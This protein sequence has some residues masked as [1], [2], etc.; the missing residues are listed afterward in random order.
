MRSPL[1]KT[2]R[3]AVLSLGAGTALLLT[4]C[5]TTW[6]G[7]DYFARSAPVTEADSQIAG[8][9]LEQ[10]KLKMRR[11]HQDLVSL[12]ATVETLRRHKSLTDIRVMESYLDGYLDEYVDPMI[13]EKDESWHP[14]LQVLDA[15]LLFA[16]AA[17]LIE[18]RDRSAVDRVIAGIEKR[19]Q[20]MNNLP[21]EYPVGTRTTLGQGLRDLHSNRR[22]I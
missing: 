8:E 9:A 19:F 18:L 15:N 20:G 12:H 21:V 11:A 10:R 1:T 4:A 7:S 22:K 16:K 17:V 13:S 2:L 3:Y 14:E 5:S 6:T